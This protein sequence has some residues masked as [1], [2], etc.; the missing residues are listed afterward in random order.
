MNILITGADG[1]IGK[2]AVA[3]LGGQHR[4]FPLMIRGMALPWVSY[5]DQIVIDLTDTRKLKLHFAEFAKKQ[6]IDVIIN[7]AFE[8]ASGNNAEDAGILCR[9]ISMV[10]NVAAI[11]QMLKP[12]KMINISSM[13]V[14]PNID[15]VYN[16]KAQIGPAANNDC[17]YGLA[18]ICSEVIL[19]FALRGERILVSHL[20]VSQV[21][22]DGMRADRTIP[23]MLREL[24]QKNT[25]TVHGNGE[26][27][28]NFI[29]VNKL[30]GYLDFFVM[31]DTAGIFN[32]GDEELSYSDLAGKLAKEY[33]NERT[34]IIKEPAGSRMK[35]RL[36]TS[37]MQEAMKAPQ[38]AKK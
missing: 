32:I 1:F 17:L 35:F 31:E 29:H 15:G 34:R 18:K 9:N 5:A 25:I 8:V 6:A 26:R 2:Y 28:S 37:K 11:A 3:H 4:I 38:H 7:L 12:K 23:V 24:R 20:R 19:D 14:Y 16:E 33:G 30:V 13:A 21:Y 36:D 22:G 10:Q 27:V